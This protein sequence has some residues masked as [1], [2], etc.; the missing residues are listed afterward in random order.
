MTDPSGQ[1]IAGFAAGSHPAADAGWLAA[2]EKII[3]KTITMHCT[4]VRIMNIIEGISIE[5][6][7]L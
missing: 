1:S 5:S 6:R 4:V 3:A 2:E 7:V